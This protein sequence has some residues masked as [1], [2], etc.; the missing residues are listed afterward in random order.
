[1]NFLLYHSPYSQATVPYTR[2][3]INL[4]FARE[5]HKAITCDNVVN[6][7]SE[8]GEHKVIIFDGMAVVNRIDIKK[9]RIKTCK[10]FA[11]TFCNITFAESEGFDEVRIIFDRYDKK[12][13]KNQA[14]SKRTHGKA[15]QYHIQ[16]EAII[17]HLTTNQFLSSTETKNKLTAFLSHKIADA[18]ISRG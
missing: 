2:Q 11:T 16:D 8:D 13:L 4:Q 18:M 10:E 3:Q 7:P 15:V 1:M 5:L 6:V 12:L 17:G 14:R 9:S